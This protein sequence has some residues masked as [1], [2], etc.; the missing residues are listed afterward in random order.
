MLRDH[1]E[2]VDDEFHEVK[3]FSKEKTFTCCCNNIDSKN[4]SS[5]SNRW[6]M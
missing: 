1:I 6:A 4:K 2:I 5:K 3:R